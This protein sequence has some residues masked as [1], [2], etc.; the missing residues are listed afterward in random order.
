MSPRDRASNERVRFGLIGCGRIAQSHLEAVAASDAARLTA[1]VEPRAEAGSAAA[2]EYRCR[3]FEDSRDPEI[4]DLVD[5]V[6]ICTPPNLHHEIARHF[7]EDGVHVFCEKPLTLRSEEAEELVALAQ[8]RRLKLMMASK[9]RYVDDVIKAKA[10]VESGILGDIILYENTF[11]SKVLMHERWN[12]RKE[13]AGGGVLIDNG[14][15]SVDIARYLLGPIRDVQAQ[16]GIAA[17]GLEVEDT[18]RLQFR[19]EAG[20]MGMVDLSWTINKE[21]DFYVSVFGSEGTLLVG[22]NG[23]RYRQDGNSKWVSFGGGYNKL[24]AF[25][26]QLANF[27]GCIRGEEAPL[28]NPDAALASVRVIEAAYASA[29]R[30]NWV[31]VNGNGTH[32]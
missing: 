10:I 5:A 3:L 30:S 14:S 11:C 2:E 8:E 22:W 16:N 21:S 32:G 13:I 18:V 26:R 12:S 19:T 7:L 1:I 17:Q 27:I 28:I 9:F 6:I 29:A 15:H 20:V 25:K 24:D 23:S 31:P 4:T